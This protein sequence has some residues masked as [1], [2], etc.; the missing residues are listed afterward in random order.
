MA[1]EV[2]VRKGSLEEAEAFFRTV[3][4]VSALNQ[5]PIARR[6]EV[7]KRTAGEHGARIF[8][9]ERRGQF[10]AFGFGKQIE[11]GLE[12]QGAR[13]EIVRV[14]G[15]EV[16]RVCVK[17]EFSG[18]LGAAS[19]SA[20]ERLGGHLHQAALAQPSPEAFPLRANQRVAFGMSDDG[21]KA[22]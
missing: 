22:H 17:Q 12:A 6:G 13:V 10:L 3:F 4:F 14:A 2:P 7:G 18:F 19:K 8:F 11:S 9:E 16:N 20:S 5:F 15:D 1:R 21:L